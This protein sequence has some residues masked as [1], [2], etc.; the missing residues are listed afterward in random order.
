MARITTRQADDQPVDTVA[1]DDVPAAP[2]IA[3][4][5]V[6][7]PETTPIPGGGRWVWSDTEPHWVPAPDPI[8]SFTE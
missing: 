8:E 6:A 2:P 5:P 3:T 1:Q 4:L 7:R